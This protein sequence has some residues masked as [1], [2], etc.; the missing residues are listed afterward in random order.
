MNATLTAAITEMSISSARAFNSSAIM[1][2]NILVPV[3]NAAGV[4]PVLNAPG[5]PPGP[6]PHF[7]GTKAEFLLLGHLEL[8]N[9][10]VFYNLPP[11]VNDV[12]R[13]H[14]L[15]GVIGLRL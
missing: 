15:A 14:T 9:F 8:V 13:S 3:R 12:Q 6:V 4:L 1:G 5:L 11:G 7:P 2:A 10:M